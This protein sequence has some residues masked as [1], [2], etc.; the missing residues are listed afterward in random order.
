MCVHIHSHTCMRMC[1]VH[2]SVCTEMWVHAHMCSHTWG[3]QESAWN[4][5]LC[6]PSCLSWRCWCSWQSL[7]SFLSDSPLSPSWVSPE[8]LVCPAVLI[9]DLSEMGSAPAGCQFLGNWPRAWVSTFLLFWSLS[10]WSQLLS[11]VVALTCLLCTLSFHQP[12]SQ[13]VSVCVCVKSG[14]IRFSVCPIYSR[15]VHVAC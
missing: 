7:K 4:S 15:T 3:A 11:P 1:I 12:L 8:C 10:R 2:L 13:C 5:A 14:Q 6:G 9:Q